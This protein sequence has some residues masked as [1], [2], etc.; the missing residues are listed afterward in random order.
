MVW[1]T[2][3]LFDMF[4]CFNTYVTD[5]VIIVTASTA[6]ANMAPVATTNLLQDNVQQVAT[7]MVSVAVSKLGYRN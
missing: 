2:T 7:S 3:V 5:T 4:T 6:P 1:K